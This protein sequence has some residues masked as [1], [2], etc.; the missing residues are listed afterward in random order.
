[1][2]R[3]LLKKIRRV[4]RAVE[5]CMTS[6]GGFSFRHVDLERGFPSLYRDDGI[7]LSDIGLDI[8]NADLQSCIEQ[9]AGAGW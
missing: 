2:V 5:K 1:M 6:I 7:H 8:F 4:N 3:I 9:A